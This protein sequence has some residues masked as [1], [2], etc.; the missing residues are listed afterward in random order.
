MRVTLRLHTAW[1]HVLRTVFSGKLCG[2]KLLAEAERN[3]RQVLPGLAENDVTL[4]LENNEAFSAAEFAGLT[5]RIANPRVGVCTDTA[6]SLGRP[7]TLDTIVDQLIEH[8]VE[9]HAKDFDIQRIDTRM[10]LVVVG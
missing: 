9:V 6:N 1:A 8:T 4:A 5:K 7:E 10:G 2:P 3:L